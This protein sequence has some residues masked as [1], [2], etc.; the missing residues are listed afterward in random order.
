M[1]LSAHQISQQAAELQARASDPTM[2]IWV[3]ASAGTGKTKVLTDRVLRLLLPKTHKDDGVDPTN[4][5][6]LTFT[7]AGANEMISRIMGVLSDWAVCSENKLSKELEKLLQEPPSIHQRDR[8]RRLF[9]LV[10][11]MPNG[12]NITTIHGFCQSLLGRFTMEAGLPPSFK[13]MD[14]DETRHLI[15]QTISS[16]IHKATIDKTIA[17]MLNQIIM[18]KNG[19]QMIKIFENILNQRHKLKATF[20]HHDGLDNLVNHIQKILDVANY[21]DSNDVFTSFF[22]HDHIPQN[23][24]FFLCDFF[25]N[26]TDKQA[27][28]AQH[29]YNFYHADKRDRFKIYPKYKEFFLTKKNTIRALPKKIDDPRAIQIFNTMADYVLEYEDHVSSLMI[30]EYTK[31]LLF[32]SVFILDEFERLKT[33]RQG[34]D[35]NDLIDK[36]VTLLRSS[37][38]AWILYKLDYKIHHIMVDESQDTNPQQWE[39]IQCLCEDFTSGFSTHD[40][41]IAKT[42]FVVGD[43][44]QSIFSFQGADAKG[45][46]EVKIKMTDQFQSSQNL[47]DVIPMN[48]SFR[49]TEAVLHVVD[50]IFQSEDMKASLT[51]DPNAYHNHTAYRLEQ[52]GRVELWPLCKTP[53][54]EE[55]ESWPMPVEIKNNQDAQYALAKTVA[56]QIHEWI[57]RQEILPSKNRAIEAQDIMILVRR[58]TS[59]VD[60]LIRCLKDYNIP[61]S[62][63][64]RLVI[65]SHIAVK[66]IVAVLNFALMPDDDLNLACVLKSPLIGWK[67]ED[68]EELCYSRKGTLWAEI[69]KNNCHAVTDYLSNLIQSLSGENAFTACSFILNTQ[70]PSHDYT[71]WQA[72]TKRLGQD[73]LDPLQE[74]LNMALEYDYKNPAIGIQGFVHFIENNTKDIKREMDHTEN[75]VRIMT[76][77]ASKGLQAPI[78]FLPDTTS[79]PQ[80][81]LDSDQGFFWIDSYTPLWSPSAT[82]FNQYLSDYQKEHQ[83]KIEDEYQRLLYVA[84]T[85]AEDRLIVCGSL[86]RTQSDCSDL[87]WYQSVKN[88]LLKTDYVEVK[89]EKDLEYMVDDN[90][91]AIIYETHRQS[92]LETSH[93]DTKLSENYDCPTWIRKSISMTPDHKNTQTI[94]PSYID[95]DDTAV[96]SP[97][98]NIDDSYR[99]RRGNLTHDLLQY[100]P[101]YNVEERHELGQLYL[102]KQASDLPPDIRNNIL[103]EVMTI[104]T[105]ETF[106]PFFSKGSMAEVPVSGKIEKPDGSYDF[107]SGQIDRLYVDGDHVWIVDYKSNRPSPRN[108]NDIPRQYKKQLSAYK[109]LIEQIY[110]KHH[111][112]C[113]LLWTDGPHMMEVV[114]FENN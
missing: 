30:F 13:I 49:S 93:K 90:P 14:D 60:Q 79:L 97:L 53:K 86:N 10:I 54:K 76:V 4:I 19:D 72:M 29:I 80:S 47:F 41:D 20:D 68:I 85:R 69:K 9:A 114:D 34:L 58:R 51:S 89:W 3:N 84:L 17:G 36:T 40:G 50:T 64:D 62:G 22:H 102:E 46:G 87:S 48:T 82:I 7:K 77:H 5:L 11:D 25:T 24:A 37:M 112:K 75:M 28:A 104:I 16:L 42:L 73:C 101:Q 98:A 95:R 78:V 38:R 110:P 32:L 65:S 108:T 33:E 23:D 27:E 94:R 56:K 88:G 18:A 44:K 71:G 15:G 59:F 12:L 74:L 1:S 113:A 57:S 39:I 70:T 31:T 103:S 55:H 96:L 81:Y 21:N 63:A 92:S 43:G 106:K 67:D 35:Y 91:S 100:L 2:N 83:K 107:I 105:D 8:A 99:F 111:V 26:G 66:D 6:C 45:Y 61:V 109:S 52:H